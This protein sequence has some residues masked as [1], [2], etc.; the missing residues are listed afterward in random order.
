MFII[1]ELI[2][3]MYP[4]VAEALA[5]RDARF[6]A[7]LA[8]RQEA[9]GANALD[10]SCGPLSKD[11]AADMRWLVETVQKETAASL[12]L[13]STKLPVIEAGLAVCK[14]KAIIN[15]T[16][17][18]ETKLAAYMRLAG[19]SG[20]DLIAL[21]VDKRGIPQDKDRRVEL[22][23][24]IVEAA[25]VEGLPLERLFLDP[26]LMPINVAQ[27]Q[28]FVILE[29]IKDLKL[30]APEARTVVGL[31]NVSQGARGR[32][33]INRAFLV[34]AQAHG[35]DAAILDPLDTELMK[36]MVAGA[37]IL[38]KYIYCDAYFDAYLKSKK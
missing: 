27:K 10:L 18:D 2:N 19:N 11:P 6:I 14:N 15:S 17:A 4:R 26:V 12:C 9:A 35:L 5:G 8:C 28:L 13:D 32:R 21:T 37:L 33:W 29:V 31:S 16:T 7:E 3:G 38:D 1:G 22:A 24:R 34:M 25:A 30:L 36:T 23:A 20:A